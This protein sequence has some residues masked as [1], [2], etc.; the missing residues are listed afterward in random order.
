MSLPPIMSLDRMTVRASNFA[1]GDFRFRLTNAL[2]GTHVHSLVGNVI[3]VKRMGVAIV[4]AIYAACRELKGIQPASNRGRSLIGG[5]VHSF[6]VAGPLQPSSPPF[7]D[8]LFRN[9]RANPRSVLTKRRA[10]LRFPL[11]GERYAALSAAKRPFNDGGPRFH[12][13]IIPLMYPCKPDIFAATYEP[14]E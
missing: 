5:S 2:G 4:A 3:E 14:I 13:Q 10:E 7:L 11:G 1:L 9:R 6:L 12:M 8:S